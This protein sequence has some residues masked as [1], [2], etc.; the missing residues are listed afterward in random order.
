VTNSE[1][2]ARASKISVLWRCREDGALLEVL[3]NGVGM[4]G[5]VP[6]RVSAYGL[7]GMKERA[8]SV[9]AKLEITSRRGEGTRVRMRKAV[10]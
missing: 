8:D 5:P 9:R 7:L 10:S 1:R 3:D 6:G 2:H 4:P